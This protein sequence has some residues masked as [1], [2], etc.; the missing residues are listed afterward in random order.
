MIKNIVVTLDSNYVMPCGVM[1]FSLCKNNEDAMIHVHAICD[2]SVT[3]LDKEKLEKTVRQFHSKEISFYE[4][5]GNP[6]DNYPNLHNVYLSKAAYY[7]LFITDILPNDV[8]KVLY[9]DCDLLV[10]QSLEE[11]YSIDLEGMALAAVIDAWLAY[12]VSTYNRLRYTPSK[13]YFNSGVLLINLA[14][15]RRNNVLSCFVD[16]LEN[17]R[18]RVQAHDQDVLNA[19]FSDKKILL[20]LKFNLQEYFLYKNRRFYFW[21]YADSFL[22]TISKPVI[23]HYTVI[24]PWHKICRHPLKRL[25]FE[26]SDQTF[27]KDFK[28]Q[29]YPIR[30]TFKGKIKYI[31]KKTLIALH[32]SKKPGPI[33]L[34]EKDFKEYP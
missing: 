16:Y 18:D 33:Y 28:L 14:Y 9:L 17:H 24:K 32:I 4:I 31:L 12:D 27:W 22:E 13:L 8:D 30:K 15:W 29:K 34:Q 5:S 3:N 19:I 10:L 23:I 1:L 11:L 25:F 2:E 21:D 20:P 7:R 6:F 26:Y